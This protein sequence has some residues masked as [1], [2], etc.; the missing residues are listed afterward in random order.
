[1]VL[2]AD[3]KRAYNDKSIIQQHSSFLT[4]FSKNSKLLRKE[5]SKLMISPLAQEIDHFLLRKHYYFSN[6]PEQG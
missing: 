3:I 5:S 2:L 1:M 4:I 6:I